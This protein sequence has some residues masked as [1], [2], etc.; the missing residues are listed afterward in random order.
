MGAIIDRAGGV[1]EKKGQA[2]VRSNIH[3]IRGSSQI[4]LGLETAR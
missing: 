2:R 1:L 4:I 3:P